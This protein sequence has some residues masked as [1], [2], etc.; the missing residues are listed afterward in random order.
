MTLVSQIKKG[1]YF[2]FA[3]LMRVGKALA[4]LPGPRPTWR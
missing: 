3:T 1:A 2:D 4:A